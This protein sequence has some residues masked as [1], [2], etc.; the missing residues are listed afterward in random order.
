MSNRRL[1]WRK[2]GKPKAAVLPP[3]N[4]RKVERAADKLLGARSLDE[5]WKEPAD[6]RKRNRFV[7][8]RWLKAQRSGK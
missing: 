6:K 3:W 2:A 7:R 1:D 5:V 4:A 8:K